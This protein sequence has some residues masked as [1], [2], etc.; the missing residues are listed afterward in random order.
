MHVTFFHE[1]ICISFISQEL[2]L[3][4]IHQ[5]LADWFRK[6]DDCLITW[7]TINKFKLPFFRECHGMS[8][9]S[10]FIWLCEYLNALWFCKTIKPQNDSNA[11]TH[12]LGRAPCCITSLISC[13]SECHAVEKCRDIISLVSY[14]IPTHWEVV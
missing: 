12:F 4:K 11:M 13:F 14:N 9:F 10:S 8:I 7:K 6:T 1:E 5:P 3:C 2:I